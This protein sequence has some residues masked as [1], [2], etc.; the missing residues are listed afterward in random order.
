MISKYTIVEKEFTGL[1]ISGFVIQNEEGKRKLLNKQDTIKLAR[2]D[3]LSNARALLDTT[4]GE[5]ILK[6][7]D[8]LLDI[9]NTDKGKALKIVLLAR[10]MDN[11]RC[12]GYKAKDNKGK[13]YKLSIEKVWQLAE[14]GSIEGV[15]G[16]ISGTSK[17]ILSTEEFN[18]NT[19]P[20]LSC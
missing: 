10:L 18:I 7:D 20:R 13:L 9:D 16:K 14:Q 17:L 19:L 11:N 12:I 3:K 5:Y 4:S 2:S 15:Q 1:E 6:T 8:S